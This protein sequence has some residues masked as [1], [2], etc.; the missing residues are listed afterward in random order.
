MAN[1]DTPFDQ[2]KAMSYNL[3]RI[4]DQFEILNETLNEDK[5]EHNS[6]VIESQTSALKEFMK[7]LK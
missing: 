5:T 2:M 1:Y 4:A 3:K 6:E 7:T